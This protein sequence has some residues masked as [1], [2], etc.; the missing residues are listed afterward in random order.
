[1]PESEYHAPVDEL[2]STG[3]KLILEMPALFK[4]RVIDG[5][6]E[7]K[8]AYDLGSAVH[9]KVLGAGS[10]IVVL[11][12][13]D[14]RTKAAQ[15]DRDAAYAAGNTP[16]LKKDMEQIDGMA[17]SVL[18]H[19]LAKKL[20]EREGH[21]EVSVFAEDDGVK[22]RCRFDYLPNEGNIAVDLKTTA[23]K[24][25]KN[26]FERTAGDLG[27]YIQRAHYLDVL[28]RATGR[29]VEMLFVVVEKSPPYAVA[30]HQLDGD[31]ARMGERSAHEARDIFKR[32][33]ES[34]VW[35]AYDV[36]I[37][38]CQPPM[39]LINQFQERFGENA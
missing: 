10:P 38:L 18:A 14:Y 9:A 37:N 36:K 31:Y 33:M 25:S 11:D 30:V 35:P 23:G 7:H 13:A 34:G 28:Y 29:D 5:N 15:S 20:H 21:P 19:P 2:S 12:Y 3:A 6:N 1:M 17:E 4:Y 26:G 8:P 39:Y 32:C 27:Y 24:A 22:L 16:M